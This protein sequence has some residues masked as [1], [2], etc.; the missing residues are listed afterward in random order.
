[1]P[2]KDPA[3]QQK[4]WREAHPGYAYQATKKWRVRNRPKDH[5]MKRDYRL[6]KFGITEAQYLR[7]FEQQDGKCAICTTPPK[8]R[9]LC[10]DHDHITK[11][12]RGLLCFHC[13]RNIVGRL[14]DGRLLRIAADYL[15]SN[16]DGRRILSENSK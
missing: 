14:H 7:M 2:Y 9:R 16:F 8:T 5:L 6:K 4:L 3:K 12:V 10:V 1:M 13:N 15:D 11:R